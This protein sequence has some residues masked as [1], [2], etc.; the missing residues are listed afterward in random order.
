MPQK[1]RLMSVII[2]AFNEEN[3]IEGC[4]KSL[5][6][7]DLPNSEFEIIVVDNASTDN[8]SNIVR[9]FPVRL[10]Y[11]KSPSVVFARQKGVTVS[12][13]NIIVSGDA[14][15]LY[16]PDWL[17]EIKKEFQ[18]DK[19]I[20]AVAG[21]IYFRNSPLFFKLLFALGQTLNFYSYK[22]FSRFP[23]VFAANFAFK[24]TALRKIGGYPMHIPELGDQ[25]YLLYK[26]FKLGDVK[27]CPKIKCYT[28]SRRHHSLRKNIVL[29]VWYRLFG[30]V[31]NSFIGKQIIGPASAYRNES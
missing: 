27:V 4:L 1:A 31:I 10:V 3:Y 5:L 22:F 28:S 17:A 2:P 26:F 29:N 20:I 23:L 7:Q 6:A 11:E 14:D 19:N 12:K 8:T 18:N 16:P 25:Q 13:G 9:K 15:T 21:Y 30:F 24:R